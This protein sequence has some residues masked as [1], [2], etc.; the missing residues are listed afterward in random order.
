MSPSI[1]NLSAIES[2]IIHTGSYTHNVIGTGANDPQKM[3]PDAS[4]EA[5]DRSITYIFAVALQD[6]GW[7]SSSFVSADPDHHV[8]NVGAVA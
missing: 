8:R 7:P 3:N 2:I 6:R 4:R 1:K 5:L